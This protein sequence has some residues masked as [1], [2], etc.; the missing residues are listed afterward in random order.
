MTPELRE[1]NKFVYSPRHSWKRDSRQAGLHR[2]I[3]DVASSRGN[4][5]IVSKFAFSSSYHVA[6][7]QNALPVLPF[8]RASV[9]VSGFSWA[10]A[11]EEGNQKDIHV[12]RDAWWL[13]IFAYILI[14][15]LLTFRCW[16]FLRA[17]T[18]P[19]SPACVK[20]FHRPKHTPG[21]YV[22]LVAFHIFF[23]EYLHLHF[24]FSV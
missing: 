6:V 23:E 13:R 2:Y 21:Y 3:I 11:E 15:A 16:I 10:T 12:L 7:F 9:L 14:V 20:A 22:S 17:F 1:S 24:C 8:S 4:K 18:K 5:W 19:H